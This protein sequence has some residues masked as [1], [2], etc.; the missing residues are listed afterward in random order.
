MGPTLG[1]FKRANEGDCAMATLQPGSKGCV[2]VTQGMK[3]TCKVQVRIILSFC[4]LFHTD[5]I[6]REVQDTLYLFLARSLFLVW[7]AR[8]KAHTIL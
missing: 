8:N 4:R 1:E 7:Q 2:Q 3:F 6:N 5:L